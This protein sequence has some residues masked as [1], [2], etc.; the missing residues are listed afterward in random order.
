MEVE[1][2]F[3]VKSHGNVPIFMKLSSSPSLVALLPLHERVVGIDVEAQA[4][5]PIC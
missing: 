3:L 2:V 1:H 5:C 4:Y